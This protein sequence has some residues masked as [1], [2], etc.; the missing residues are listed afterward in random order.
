LIGNFAIEDIS[1]TVTI[2][3]ACFVCGRLVM[4]GKI[5]QKKKEAKE[6]I[7]KCFTE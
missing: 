3:Y 5:E 4:D 6:N 2:F 7:V 1:F